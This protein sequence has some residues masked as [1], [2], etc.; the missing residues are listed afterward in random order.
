MGA[1]M[2][3]RVVNLNQVE[4]I[5]LPQ[6]SWSRM[7]LTD[8]TAE[9]NRSSLGYS[10]FTPGT[11]LGMVSHDVEEVAYVVAG[12]GE[13]R[14]E[15]GAV[16]FGPGDALFIRNSAAGEI[17]LIIVQGNRFADDGLPGLEVCRPDEHLLRAALH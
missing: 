14:L 15:E 3:V 17:K 9:G 16:A 11:V 13:L 4:P 2:P 8:R 10:V 12:R 5:P 6:G 7:L 1:L